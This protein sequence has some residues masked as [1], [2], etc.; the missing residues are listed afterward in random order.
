M[1]STFK[2]QG[3]TEGDSLLFGTA[4]IFKLPCGGDPRGAILVTSHHLLD[5]LITDRA[6]LGLRDKRWDGTWEERPWWID[7]RDDG[8]PLWVR[9]KKADVAAMCIQLPRFAEVPLNS[10]ELL[11]D[12][13]TFERY[14][15]HPGDELL[16]LGYSSQNGVHG[17]GGFPILRGGRIASYPLFPV[18]KYPTFR[19]DVEIFR[20][21]SG[22][23]V[24]FYQV[25]RMYEQASHPDQQIQFIAGLLTRQWFADREEKYPLKVAE[26]VHAH[27]IR[28]IV[29]K[30]LTKEVDQNEVEKNPGSTM[31]EALKKRTSE[32][33]KKREKLINRP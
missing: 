28:E 6:V 21:Y 33:I 16:C 19:Y 10:L 15:M 17:L 25:G 9:H 3:T 32:E 23:P 12:R 14:E 13:E 22:G 1:E 8:K 29:G 26:V 20:G 24:Y 7:I 27:F 31:E 4:F 5:S 11:A 2:L 18:D 30:L